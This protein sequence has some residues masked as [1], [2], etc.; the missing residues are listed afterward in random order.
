M[1]CGAILG[2]VILSV[3]S[4]TSPHIVIHNP[5]SDAGLGEVAMTR[6]AGYLRLIVRRVAE[7]HVRLGWKGIDPDPGNLGVVV[8]ICDDLLNL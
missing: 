7:L 8:R 3:A 2:S 6:C 1:A 4:D 5:F